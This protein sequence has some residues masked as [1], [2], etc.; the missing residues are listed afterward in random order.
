MLVIGAKGLAKEIIQ[1]LESNDYI[2]E[3][4]CYDD[5]NVNDS[6]ILFNKYKILKD[7]NIAA[8][9]LKKDN[10]FL[11][12]LGS[13]NL[14]SMLCEKFEKLGGDLQSLKSKNVYI[15]NYVNIDIGFTLMNSVNISNGVNIGK[16]LLAYY[17]VIITHDVTIG[18]FVE[19]SPGC[20]L[21]GHVKIENNVQIGA[22]AIILPKVVIGENSIVGA[23]TVVTKSIPPN[24]LAVGVPARLI[25][26]KKDD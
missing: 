12:G 5:V 2:G 19:L 1:L 4:V 8:K 10:K 11:L 16:A 25:N 7:Q 9:L 21:L 15:G 20:K 14:R 22:G 18:N 3:I 26:K 17:G 24:S 23:G 13:P 6:N